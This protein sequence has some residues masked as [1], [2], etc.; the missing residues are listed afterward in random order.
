VE[1]GQR[2]ETH[3]LDH[4][5]IVVRISQEIRLIEIVDQQ[6]GPVERKISCGQA[7][8]AMILTH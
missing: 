4:L 7:V 2:F 3:Q 8:Q 5:G 1:S 6:V